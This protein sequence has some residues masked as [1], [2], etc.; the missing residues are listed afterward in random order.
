MDIVDKLN[1]DQYSFLGRYINYASKL[2]DAPKV[3]HLATGLTMLA[4]CCGSEIKFPGFGG[5]SYW[6]NLYVLLISPS[7]LY[8]KSTALGMGKDILSKVD[9][10]LIMSGEQ[11]R[12]KFINKLAG[13]PTIFYPISEFS[14][15]LG[16]WQREYMSGMKEIVTDLYDP[17]QVYVRE[18]MYKGEAGK[19]EIQKPAITILAA[20]TIDWLRERLSEGDLRGGLMGRFLM[21]PGNKKGQSVG[22]ASEEYLGEKHVIIDYLKELAKVNGSWLDVSDIREPYNQWL[23]AIERDIELNVNPEL[24]GFQSRIGNHTLKLLTLIAVSE[25]NFC[26]SRAAVRATTSHLN[27]AAILAKWLMD[28]AGVI[29]STGFTRSKTEQSVQKLLIL[30]SRSGGISR[31]EALR[32]LHTTAREFQ[33]LVDTAIERKEIIATSQ[34][35]GQKS[36]VYY[37]R[38]R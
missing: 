21:F 13:H 19:I 26:E 8:R 36:S 18:T 30:A 25:C 31:S 20:S 35:D 15:M 17:H 27:Q 22:L 4:A 23:T 28:E 24:V 33:T 29:A 11:T 14:S 2:T 38:P 5:Q 7:G 34:K 32:A 3:F 6:P 37:E 16:L 12:E 10:S 1:F 9:Y